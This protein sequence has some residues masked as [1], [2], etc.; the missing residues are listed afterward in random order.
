MRTPL[1]VIFDIEENEHPR[2]LFP[3]PRGPDGRGGRIT[4]RLSLRFDLLCFQGIPDGQ[5][6]ILPS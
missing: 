5:A 6:A 4:A 2:R 3:Y 1:I